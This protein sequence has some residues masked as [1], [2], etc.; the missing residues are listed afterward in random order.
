MAP[1]R[2]P[3]V[4]LRAAAGRLHVEGVGRAGPD[5]GGPRRQPASPRTAGQRSR[6]LPSRCVYRCRRRARS[7]GLDVVVWPL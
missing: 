2:L 5:P 1:I 6:C 7:Q 3:P 4:G